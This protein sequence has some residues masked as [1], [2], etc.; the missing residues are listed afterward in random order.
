M[1]HQGPSPAQCA[2]WV[3]MCGREKRDGEMEGQGGQDKDGRKGRGERTDE[4]GGDLRVHL[5]EIILSQN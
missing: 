2:H 1:D 3:R 5:P 4:G